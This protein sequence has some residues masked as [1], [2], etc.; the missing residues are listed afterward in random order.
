MLLLIC[1]ECSEYKICAVNLF[2]LLGADANAQASRRF[3]AVLDDRLDAVMAGRA[4]AYAS[5]NLAKVK[6]ELIMDNQCFG[7]INLVEMLDSLDRFPAQ[8]HQRRGFHQHDPG[9]TQCVRRDNAFE[10][11]LIYPIWKPLLGRKVIKRREADIMSRP[12][13]LRTNITQPD[14]QYGDAE[15]YVIQ[16]LCV[17]DRL[18]FVESHNLTLSLNTDPNNK[19]SYKLAIAVF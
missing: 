18:S 19:L 17:M 6:V 13:V 14:N 8:V 5:T 11:F 7:I 4:A 1:C 2:G 10:V 3:P 9:F 16:R 12:I 15:P